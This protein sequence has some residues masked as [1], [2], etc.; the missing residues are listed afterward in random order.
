ME[1]DTYLFLLNSRFHLIILFKGTTGW[2][3]IP[4]LF[5]GIQV[6]VCDQLLLL[7]Y[8]TNEAT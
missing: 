3:Q 4:L 8:K 2:I 5:H 1:K 7:F 6:F